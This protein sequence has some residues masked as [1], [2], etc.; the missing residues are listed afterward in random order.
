MRVI[1]VA[2]LQC[3]EQAR[4]SS[5]L[6]DR[7]ERLRDET[8]SLPLS[9]ISPATTRSP[10]KSRVI[11]GMIHPILRARPVRRSDAEP[12]SG[13]VIERPWRPIRRAPKWT[14]APFRRGAHRPPSRGITH[15]RWPWLMWEPHRGR[16]AAARE[17]P[18]RLGMITAGPCPPPAR[19]FPAGLAK[20]VARRVCP[21]LRI[22]DATAYVL[23][24]RRFPRKQNLD[25][26]LM[27]S[28]ERDCRAVLER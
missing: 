22:V 7:A 27:A 18:S 28:K 5:R 24:G 25:V 15:R 13:F 1:R 19:G 16:P 10:S 2:R 3:L 12:N 23:Q 20:S 4:A 6:A 11:R 17:R 9:R 21:R 26:K 14:L 8:P